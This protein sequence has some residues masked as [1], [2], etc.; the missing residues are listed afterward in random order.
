[1]PIHARLITREAD[2]TSGTVTLLF[3]CEQMH[4]ELVRTPCALAVGWCLAPRLP[5]ELGSQTLRYIGADATR[6]ALSVIQNPHIR[7]A[8]MALRD[9]EGSGT[10][11]PAAA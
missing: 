1:M 11:A 7:P 2:P 10:L 6:Q 3:R 9:Y 4:V 5:C 8:L